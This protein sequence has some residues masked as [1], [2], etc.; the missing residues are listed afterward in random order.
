MIRFVRW[1]FLL[2]AAFLS[3]PAHAGPPD[4]GQSTAPHCIHLVAR[5]LSGVPDPFGNFCVT[6]RDATGAPVAGALVEVAFG[7]CADVSICD[8]NDDSAVLVDCA[9]HTVSRIAGADGAACFTLTGGTRVGP[10]SA[11][12]CAQIRAN[13]VVL[14]SAS[15]AAFD[16]DS[17]PTIGAADG[18][19]WLSTYFNLGCPRIDCDC[20][21]EI[22]AADFSMWQAHYFGNWVQA[23]SHRCP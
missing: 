14:G 1:S 15:V 23:C 6:A 5:N 19:I 20:S 12:G 2:A 13:G 22:T 9:T 11:A 10:C 8:S 16:Y 21:G 18:S 17:A 3:L 7:G 4:P